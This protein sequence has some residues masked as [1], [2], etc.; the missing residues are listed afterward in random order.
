MINKKILRAAVIVQAV[1]LL[2]IAGLTLYSSTAY[3]DLLSKKNPLVAKY[4]WQQVASK[5]DKGVV[6]YPIEDDPIVWVRSTNKPTKDPAI[7][8]KIQPGDAAQFFNLKNNLW[9]ATESKKLRVK[10]IRDDIMAIIAE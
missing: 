4:T 1:C 10:F 5:G 2:F 8:L 3:A 6:I 9:V 7:S